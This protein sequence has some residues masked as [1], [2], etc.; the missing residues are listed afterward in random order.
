MDNDVF[1]L[2]K[3]G[4]Q[5]ATKDAHT[6]DGQDEPS[7]TNNGPSCYEDERDDYKGWGCIWW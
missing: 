3:E 7:H 5:A 4:D 6:R 2:N 1:V